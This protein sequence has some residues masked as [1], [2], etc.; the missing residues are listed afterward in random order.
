MSP[1]AR[2]CHFL[3]AGTLGFNAA[4]GTCA[5]GRHWQAAVALLGALNESRPEEDRPFLLERIKAVEPV[6]APRVP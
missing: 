2:S 6:L 5:V 4:I 1:S 3:P